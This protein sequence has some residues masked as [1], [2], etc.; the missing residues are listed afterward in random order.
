[1]TQSFELNLQLN[2]DLTLKFNKLW[3]TY[4]QIEIKMCE[5]SPCYRELLTKVQIW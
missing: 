4:N 5:I 2:S 3:K 1:M